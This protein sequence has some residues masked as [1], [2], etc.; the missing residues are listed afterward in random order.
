[1]SYYYIWGLQDGLS[2]IIVPIP[3]PAGTVEWYE[4]IEGYNDGISLMIDLINY[5]EY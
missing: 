2:H 4:W 1:M 5:K 3:F